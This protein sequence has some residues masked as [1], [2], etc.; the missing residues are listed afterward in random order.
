M[1][2]L[3]SY[4]DTSISINQMKKIEEE[5]DESN[6]EDKEIELNSD[7]V[8]GDHVNESEVQE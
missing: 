7:K 5:D 1:S 3:N 4:G 2:V 8:Q 6:T